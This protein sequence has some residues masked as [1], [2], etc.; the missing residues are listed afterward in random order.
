[1]S[2]LI[3]VIV[4]ISVLLV[5]L[6]AYQYFGTDKRVISQRMELYLNRSETNFSVT[7]SVIG[8]EKSLDGWRLAIRSVS[9]YFESPRWAHLIEHKLIQAGIPMRG[10]EFLVICCGTG[11]FSAVFCG[12]VSGGKVLFVLVGGI[13]GFTVPLLV[14]KLKV[15]RRVKAFTNQLGDSLVLIANALRTGYSFLQAIEMVSREMP[16][17]ISE[18]FD[19]VLREMN[20]GVGT[21]AAM[22]N[23]AKRVNS[24]DLDLVVTAVLIQRQV[25]GNLAEV[26]D[27]I[28]NTIRDRIKIKSQIRTLTAQGRI[29]GLIVSLLPLGTGLMIYVVNPEYIKLLFSSPLGNALLAVGVIS[30]V[31]GMLFIRKIVNIEI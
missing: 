16:K 23:L 27:N 8:Q 29:S 6:A 13:S 22:N 14:L 25:G 7:Q 20:L 4:F 18:E 30:Q 17:P 15:G 10:S 12:A 5:I 9:K 31:I 28:S 2:I 26:L 11:L 24:D 1:M 19:R 21:E 3:T